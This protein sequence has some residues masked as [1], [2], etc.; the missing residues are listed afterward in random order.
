MYIN[1]KHDLKVNSQAHDNQV[2]IGISRIQEPSEQISGNQIIQEH[3]NTSWFGIENQ[4][5]SIINNS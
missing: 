1:Q 3:V 2:E 4:D 5:N